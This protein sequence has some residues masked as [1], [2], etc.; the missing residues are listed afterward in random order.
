MNSY[1][2]TIPLLRQQTTS[3][4]QYAGDEFWKPA[5]EESVACRSLEALLDLGLGIYKSIRRF[6]NGEKIDSEVLD[7]FVWWLDPCDVVERGIR[8]FEALNHDVDGAG[9]FRNACEDARNLTKLV[10]A[11]W[12][13]QKIYSEAELQKLG[14]QLPPEPE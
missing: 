4:S 12:R 5:Y 9:E 11:T 10:P 3:Y 1:A 6:T 14:I 8:Y 2:N 7:L 13:G